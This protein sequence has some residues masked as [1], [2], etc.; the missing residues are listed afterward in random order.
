MQLD[1][2]DIEVVR[3]LLGWIADKPDVLDRKGE[4][5][6]ITPPLVS[7]ILKQKINIPKVLKWVCTSNKIWDEALDYCKS[8]VLSYTNLHMVPDMYENIR[9]LIEND[10]SISEEKKNELFRLYDK[11]DRSDFFTAILLYVIS[12]ENRNISE[13]PISNDIPLLAETSF[14]CPLCHTPLVETIRSAPIKH[15]EIVNIYPDNIKGHEKEFSEVEVP[16]RKKN[17]NNKIALCKRHAEEYVLAPTFEVYS[18][19]NS[20]KKRMSGKHAYRAAIHDAAL[21]DEIKQVL[22]GLKQVDPKVSLVDLPLDALRLD[23]KIKPKYHMLKTEEISRVLRYY[24]YVNDLFSIMERESAADFD[25]IASEIRTAFLKLEKAKLSQED[26]V[27]HLA[28]WISAKTRISDLRPCHI[29]VAF[30]IQNC[31]VFNE[32][33]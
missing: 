24:N 18:I 19:L 23:Q 21:E 30:F 8:D 25:L 11:P 28:E 15:Y 31:E 20:L 3:L 1:N 16:S 33:P 22:S 6:V 13:P 4:P 7:D 29:V 32:I 2:S 5:F 9:L 26:I 17:Q 14:E 12:K 27:D 10:G